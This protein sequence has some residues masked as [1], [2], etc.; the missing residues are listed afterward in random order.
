[1]SI[2][3]N[4]RYKRS[5]REITCKECGHTEDFSVYVCSHCEKV[6]TNYR[7]HQLGTSGGHERY[8]DDHSDM[9]CPCCMCFGR[10]EK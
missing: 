7:E 6:A 9:F 1:M 4:F 10:Y 8:C 5:E 2:V 3:P